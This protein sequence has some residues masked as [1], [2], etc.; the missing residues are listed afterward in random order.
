MGAAPLNH[1]ILT[2]NGVGGACA[3]AAVLLKHPKARLQITSL[4]HLPKAVESLTTEKFS[5][6]VHVCGMADSLLED[7]VVEAVRAFAGKATVAW[8][9]GGVSPEALARAE[10]LGRHVKR[11]F[12]DT[13]TDTEAVLNA[14]RP[15]DS[16]RALLLREVSIEA[17]QEKTPC[18]ELNVY[19]HDLVNAANRRFYHFGDDEL[20]E[21]ACRFLAGLEEKTR[22]LDRAIEQ[23]QQTKNELYAQGSSRVIKAMRQMLGKMGPVP[24]PV[25]IL[26]PTGSGKELMARTLHITSG[27]KGAFVPV[28]CAVLGGNLPLVED[29]LFGHVKGAFTGA[30]ADGR[31]A[32]DEAD[33]GSLF[34]DEIGE[35]PPT[36]Q[37]QLLRVLEDKEVRPV[38]S[39]KTHPVDVRVVAATHRDLAQMVREKRFREDLYYRINLLTLRVPALRERAEDMK[40]IAKEVLAHLEKNKYPL[41]LDRRDWDALHAYDWPGNVRQF[42]NVLK[43]AAYMQRRVAELLEEEKTLYAVKEADAEASSVFCPTR[44]EDVVPADKIYGLYIKHVL[45][46]FEGNITQAAR[47]LDIAPNT[48]R[49]NIEHH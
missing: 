37:A 10:G 49:K 9:A 24:E 28:N 5:G 25:L 18:S 2:E 35:L 29:R 22:E 31:G 32:F 36:V 34:L 14:L 7:E 40:S 19:C 27:R 13:G 17:A 41:K 21:K 43:R 20:N 42:L 3:A 47:A 1:I 23:Y 11:H 8:Y 4:I 33:L 44:K 48:V 16:A 30:D 38:G 12:A 6:T 39:M 45:G 15:G 26:G 46:L